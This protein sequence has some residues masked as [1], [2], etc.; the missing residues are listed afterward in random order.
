MHHLLVRQ[1]GSRIA[2]AVGE[3]PGHETFESDEPGFV[4]LYVK[5][6]PKTPEEEHRRHLFLAVDRATRWMF[7]KL[8]ADKTAACGRAFWAALPKSC[9]P[10]SKTLLRE[11]GTAFTDR[12]FGSKDH[13]ATAEHEFDRPCA[14]PEIAPPLTQAPHIT[15]QRAGRA[16]QWS[17]P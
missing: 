2:A 5:Y 9:P 15:D 12:L 8:Y 17:E 14:A 10:R 6:L 3:K 16:L 7:V 13:Q 4:H 11:N 1:G